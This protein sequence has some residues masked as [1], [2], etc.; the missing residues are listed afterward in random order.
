MCLR[1]ACGVASLERKRSERSMRHDFS[2][3][4]RRLWRV[5]LGGEGAYRPVLC[6]PHWPMGRCGN[7]PSLPARDNPLRL[8][9]IPDGAVIS[10]R[11]SSLH[12]YETARKQAYWMGL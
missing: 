8:L 12:H 6:D 2:K 5:C 11:L 9:A 3:T 10:A 7:R 4:L 1:L